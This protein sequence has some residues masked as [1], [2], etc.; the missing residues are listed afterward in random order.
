MS[1][2]GLSFFARARFA[3]AALGAAVLLA[4]TGCSQ[5][6]G[7]RCEVDSDCSGGLTC[8]LSNTSFGI[9]RSNTTTTAPDAAQTID[10]AAPKPDVPPP[11]AAPD[12]AP[13]DT[14][15][16]TSDAG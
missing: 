11:D 4:L 8:D 14:S 7:D 2:T 10:V 13:H 3:T 15:A 12:T 6:E 16:D 1:M 9:C 5:G